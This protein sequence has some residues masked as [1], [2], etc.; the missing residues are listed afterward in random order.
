M[1]RAALPASS[2][3]AGDVL[4]AQGKRGEA[5]AAGT[6]ARSRSSTSAAA[7][8][9]LVQLKPTRSAG[10][11][12]DA[13]AVARAARSVDRARLCGTGGLRQFL[14][15]VG[16]D[17]AEDPRS[18]A[19]H[20]G[21]GGTRLAWTHR[22]GPSQDGFAPVFAEGSVYAASTQGNVARID[23][24]T[25][26]VRWQVGSRHA[27]GSGVGTDGSVTVVATR[28]HA[29]RARRPARAQVVGAA[30][31]RGR[32]RTGGR[33]GSR[34]CCAVR[35]PRAGLRRRHR[36]APLDLPAPGTAAGSA[37]DRVDRNRA[38]HRLRRV[39][40][41]PA[42]RAQP[43]ERRAALGGHG[44]PAAWCDRDRAHR[45]R[46]RLAAGQRT[47]SVRGELPGRLSCF[48]APTG[49]PLWARDVSSARGL[50][51]DARLVTSPTTATGCTRSRARARASGARRARAARP[52]A[53]LSLGRW[54]WSATIRAWSTCCRVTTARSRVVS[55]PTAARS[56]P[57]RW[58]RARRVVQTRGGTL[59]PSRSTSHEPFARRGTAPTASRPLDGQRRRMSAAGARDRRSPERGQV[60]AVQSPDARRAAIVADRPA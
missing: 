33:A 41:R 16:S 11:R 52:S 9:R 31:G 57:R 14:A 55:Q 35:Q 15:M 53:P 8:R 13:H 17:Q 49:R 30:G 45:R 18:A 4:V 21:G 1:P 6:S 25:G 32:D 7:L 56:S 48:D 54:S 26:A 36:Q 42:G 24:A 44:G 20:G 37:P 51:V 43:R 5:R 19:G 2:P 28:R 39:A 12:R 60:D 59:A 22:I 46:R 23:P 34:S 50:D 10:R 58:R 29:D 27:L 47:R 38:R 40:R 3:T